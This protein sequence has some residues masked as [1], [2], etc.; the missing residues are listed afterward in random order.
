MVGVKGQSKLRVGVKGW[1]KLLVA[2]KGWSKLGVGFIGLEVSK[3][4]VLEVGVEYLGG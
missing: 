2:I 3:G 1:I 4:L